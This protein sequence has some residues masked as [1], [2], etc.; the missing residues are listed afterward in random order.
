MQR[1]THLGLAGMVKNSMGN[2]ARYEDVE[3]LQADYD[4]QCH[5]RD[6]YREE[7]KRYREALEKIDWMSGQARNGKKFGIIHAMTVAREALTKVNKVILEI[8][9]E[10]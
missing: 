2:W 9:E 3:E 10:K 7:N 5:C 6:G 4:L 8:Q 1:Y